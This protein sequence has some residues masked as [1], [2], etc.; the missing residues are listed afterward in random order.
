MQ[1]D[2]PQSSCPEFASVVRA[3][4]AVGS[5]SQ[6]SGVRARFLDDV[7]RTYK[8]PIVKIDI[9]D[10]EVVFRGV[11]SPSL[12]VGTASGETR[13]KL[14]TQQAIHEAGARLAEHALIVLAFPPEDRRT[15]ESKLARSLVRERME[16]D[17]FI[18]CGVIED[19]RLARGTMRVSVLLG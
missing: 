15:S 1:H 10:L 18:I 5:S 8:S 9:E 11:R 17:T 13:A 6:G 3:A 2:P 16:P 4:L 14:A 7:V 12:G 19:R